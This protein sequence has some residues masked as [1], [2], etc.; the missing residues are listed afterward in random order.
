MLTFPQAIRTQRPSDAKRAAIKLL[1]RNSSVMELFSEPQVDVAPSSRDPVWLTSPPSMR[2]DVVY[3]CSVFNALFD[4]QRERD[5]ESFH[6]NV[7]ALSGHPAGALC[8]L[9][10]LAQN[11]LLWDATNDAFTAIR[12]VIRQTLIETVIRSWPQYVALGARFGFTGISLSSLWRGTSNLQ[13]VL[14]VMGFSPSQET[15]WEWLDDK[16]FLWAMTE[17]LAGRPPRD[18]EVHAFHADSRPDMT[19]TK[20]VPVH[21]LTG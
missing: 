4:H 11:T 1:R 10:Q 2:C 20:N 13:R 21:V 7:L 19:G 18:A 15:R 6:E 16:A 12:A 9:G 8:I 5:A 17:T 14:G 3:A